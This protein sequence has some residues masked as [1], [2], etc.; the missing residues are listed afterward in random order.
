M[1]SMEDK[2]ELTYVHYGRDRAEIVHAP[3]IA[4]SF[5][6]LYVNRREL[7][8]FM[9]TP[10]KVEYLAVGF[11]LAEGI[12]RSLEDVKTMRAYDDER[13]FWYLPT[14]GLNH[15]R[16]IQPCGERGGTLDVRLRGKFSMP[17]RRV[18]TSGCGGGVTFQDLIQTQPRLNSPCTV[19]PDQIFTLMKRL[20]EQADLYRVCGGVHTSALAEGDQLLVVAEDI[21]RHNTLDKIRG[22][23][24]M[25]GIATQGR[26]L[27]STGRI[28]SEMLIKARKMETPVVAS[29]TS[30]TALSV[31]LAQAWGI[32]LI[33][34]VQGRSMNVYAGAERVQLEK[35]QMTMSPRAAGT[36]A[37][38]D[39]TRAQRASVA[40]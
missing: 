35:V 20:Q 15:W 28:S 19:K 33:G 36:P 10:T 26:I 40:A 3:V 5:W 23:C 17:S 22:E 9:C 21:G 34:Y 2:V 38:V 25:R 18:L 4:E 14:V 8:T 32:T 11:L 30:P 37:A 31:E 27:L 7:V 1:K 12:I 13:T 29:R 24:L 6:T 16:E 39:E